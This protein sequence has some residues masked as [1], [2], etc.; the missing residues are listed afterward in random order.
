MDAREL[1]ALR[2]ELGVSPGDLAVFIGISEVTCKRYETVGSGVGPQR[3]QFVLLEAIRDALKFAGKQEVAQAVLSASKDHRGAI[4]TVLRLSN[5]QKFVQEMLDRQKGF[6][7][8]TR[9]MVES[10]SDR[11]KQVLKARCG[12]V[13]D[14]GAE[15]EK[16]DR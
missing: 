11:E 8:H 4:L 16:N 10:L 13:W 7:E 1:Q 14:G 9:L 3:L 12:C 15:N 2:K 6:S 5:T